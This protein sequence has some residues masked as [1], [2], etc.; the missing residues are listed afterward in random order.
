M[1][2]GNVYGF[3]ISERRKDVWKN[4]IKILEEVER[5]CDKYNLTY[6]AIAGTLI[7]A[8]RDKGFIPWDDDI[9]LAMLRDDY[10]K[11]C[12][13]VSK[14]LTPP[15]FYQSSDTDNGYYYGHIK[16]RKSDTTAIRKANWVTNEKFNQG[17]FLDIF[18]LDNV[19][20]N[21][22]Q[23][24]KFL[25]SVKSSMCKQKIVHY[26]YF[27]EKAKHNINIKNVLQYIVYATELKIIGYKKFCN[28]FQDK[29]KKYQN[30]TN[31]V[32]LICEDV[33]PKDIWPLGDFKEVIKVP[34]E[35]TFINIPQNYDDILSTRFGNWKQPSQIGSSHGD[36][37]YDVNKSYIEYLGKSNEY[38]KEGY[39]DL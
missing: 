4:E 13:V 15:Y 20:D 18:P 3:E 25:K 34:F 23:C 17:I 29:I 31:T 14:E 36:V 24:K 38:N 26:W 10:D 19:P 2:S 21:K 5:I 6:F 22:N 32:G 35:D 11:F 37:F 7:G 28:Y 1:K 39:F 8:V 9:D 33:N 16:I 12:E 30:Q 27:E